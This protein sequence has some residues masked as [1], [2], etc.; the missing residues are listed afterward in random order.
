MKD[1]FSTA[2][3]D[4]LAQE[5]TP[6]LVRRIEQ[7]GDW[8]ALWACLQAS[9][10]ADA[11]VP[12]ADGGAGLT[13]RDM[14]GVFERC[15]AHAVPL[16]FGETV[17]ARGLLA[18]AGIG[19]AARPAGPITFAMGWRHGKGLRCDVAHGARTATHVIVQADGAWQM[20]DVASAT[21]AGAGFALDLALDW[22]QEALDRALTLAISEPWSDLA[23]R[24]L[25]ACVYAALLAGAAGRVFDMTLAYANQREQFGRVIGKFQA[26]QHHLA[27]MSEHVA[28]ARM[29]AEIGCLSASWAPDAL[30]AAVAKA[31]T[32]EAALEVA[33]IGHS[34][35]GA[36]GF[37][38][39]FDLQLYTRRLHAWRRAGGSETT[40]HEAVGN[41]LVGDHSGLTVDLVCSTLHL[42][43]E[44]AP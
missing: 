14:F 7:G 33:R 5:C 20:L 40:W 18:A 6:E 4:L 3:G 23:V 30:R 25:Q 1:S 36:I 2:I 12:E 42:L 39:E 28:A 15:G 32:S 29:A 31:R 34:L 13:L 44:A 27:V 9:G 10:F 43:P 11:L 21:A 38:E 16:P 35:H 22:P 41:V 24:T 19:A 37:T 17:L 8:Q 26:V